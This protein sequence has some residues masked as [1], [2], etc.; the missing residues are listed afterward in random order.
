MT[1]DH[2]PKQAD[3]APLGLRM[4]EEL[5]ARIKRVAEKQGRSMN[6][7]IVSALE[8]AFP[9][10]LKEPE[11]LI[12]FSQSVS[13]V[14]KAKQLLEQLPQETPVEL[15]EE[16]IDEVDKV[17]KQNDKFR[18]SLQ[19]KPL[20]ELDLEAMERIE[21]AWKSSQ[22]DL[23]KLRESLTDRLFSGDHEP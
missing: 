14:A 8:K 16:V 22:S 2:K 13:S 12:A 1:S 20:P 19:E 3:I 23:M 5:K 10:T 18:K 15:I 7:E 6:A 4:P 21:D 9:A 17:I 11:V